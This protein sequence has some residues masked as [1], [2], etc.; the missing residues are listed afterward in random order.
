MFRENLSNVVKFLAKENEIHRH[1]VERLLKEL[2]EK[3][4]KTET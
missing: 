1:A 3:D 2:N 4:K